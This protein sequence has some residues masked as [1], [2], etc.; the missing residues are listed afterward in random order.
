MSEEED[1]ITAVQAI[2]IAQPQAT[3]REIHTT[4]VT[5]ETWAHITLSEAKRACSKAAKRA[6]SAS[7]ATSASK[8]APA[9]SE[10]HKI[11][12]SRGALVKVPA[13]GT[14]ADRRHLERRA[15]PDLERAPIQLKA[16]A[17]QTRSIPSATSTRFRQA[18]EITDML[19]EQVSDLPFDEPHDAPIAE[20]VESESIMVGCASLIRA[21]VL[22]D[23]R[24]GVTTD[25]LVKLPMASVW[26]H[27]TRLVPLGSSETNLL[28]VG[29]RAY[30]VLL[31]CAI[32]LQLMGRQGFV[33]MNLVHEL[34]AHAEQG[35]LESLT[36]DSL[37]LGS[38][39][40]LRFALASLGVKAARRLYRDVD[41]RKRE[42]PTKQLSSAA[43]LH[44][45]EA[46]AREQCLFDPM[47]AVGHWNHGWVA[48]QTVK[49]CNLNGLEAAADCLQ[50]D[51]GP[52]RPRAH[53]VLDK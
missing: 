14:S 49:Q 29:H 44:S 4:L 33:V 50:Y 43:L 15:E 10:P 26:S 25:V 47:S 2:K 27:A 24:V 1:L 46:F 40:S 9:D 36:T 20:L 18:Y 19:A 16:G 22:T 30:V 17:L 11:S 38:A 23:F 5:E 39:A 8:A 37:A 32:R 3:A 12:S 6:A 41:M 21:M 48:Q 28:N 31:A 42:M 53:I 52:P 13:R 51:L 7:K 45:I 34:H 35:C